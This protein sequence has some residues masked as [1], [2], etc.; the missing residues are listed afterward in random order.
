M[1]MLPR[2]IRNFGI[3]KIS[4]WISIKLYLLTKQLTEKIEDRLYVIN[5]NE[6]NNIET[7]SVIYVEEDNT[8]YFDV[9]GI[10]YIPKRD[11]KI[12]R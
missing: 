5:L 3:Q 1:L 10:D 4:K 12:R 6:F 2:C 8:T 9:F 11:W 7:I